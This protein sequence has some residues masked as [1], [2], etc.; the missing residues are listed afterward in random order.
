MGPTEPRDWLFFVV[1]R[2]D[3]DTTLD[4]PSGS[5]S[6]PAELAQRLAAYVVRICCRPQCLV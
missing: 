5:G 6:S 4:V 1:S 2:F 3:F